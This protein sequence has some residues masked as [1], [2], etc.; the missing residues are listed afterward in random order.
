VQAFAAQR[1]PLPRAGDRCVV[2]G[3]DGRPLAV[4]RTTDVRAGPLPSA[5]DRF[6]Q[7]QGEGDRTRAW[8]LDA[9][10]RFSSRQCTAMGLTFSG[11]IGV[12]FE[13]FDLV[14]PRA[15]T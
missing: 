5:D 6:A 1:E 15:R 4:V 3:G 9:H 7:D 11:A 10:T 14:W 13:R 8:W 12:V 2:P